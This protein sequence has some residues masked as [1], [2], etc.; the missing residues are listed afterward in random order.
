MFRNS[1][2]RLITLLSGFLLLASWS[3][4]QENQLRGIPADLRSSLVEGIQQFVEA[5]RKGDWDQVSLLLGEFRG[6][7]Y[8]RRYTKAHKECLIEQMKSERML[9]FAPIG[10]SFSTEILSRPLSQKWWYIRGIAEFDKDGV[11]RKTETAI[12]AYRFEGH[13]F[14]TPPNFD[15]QWEATKISEVDF[16][17]DLSGHLKVEISPNCPLEVVRVSVRIDPEYRSLRRL[18]FVLRNNSKKEVDGLGFRI[19][20]IG[21]DGGMST[22]M[23]FYMGPGEIVASPDNIKYAGYAYYCEGESEKR[24]IIDWVRF[25]DGS[26]WKLRASK[27]KTSH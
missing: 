23:P 13:W 12:T 11:N 2:I 21:R 20:Q 25:K 1:V 5:Q 16:A 6:S 26:R 4:A 22:G 9:T 10:A 3:A 19:V 18:S 7:S 24:F 15:R 14:F 17:K 8:G 27:K